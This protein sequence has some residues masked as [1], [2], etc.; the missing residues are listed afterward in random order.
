[1]FWS[2]RK[3]MRIKE[4][5]EAE[6]HRADDNAIH[7]KIQPLQTHSSFSGIVYV[8]SSTLYVDGPC[9]KTHPGLQISKVQSLH[10]KKCKV[11]VHGEKYHVILGFKTTE[12]VDE[13]LT[14]FQ[15]LPSGGI[16]Y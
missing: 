5:L 7:C 3:W 9:F 4:H 15:E 14:L 2:K 8:H 11:I 10:V 13:F 12:Q 6:V 1:M 16:W